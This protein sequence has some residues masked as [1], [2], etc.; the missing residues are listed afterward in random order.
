MAKIHMILQGKGGVG[1]SFIATM[2]AQH[3]LAK[4][5]N[6][7]CI[8]TDP[9]N[10]T[11]SGFS[12]LNVKQLKLMEG[13][14]INPRKFDGLIELIA[15]SKSDVI[16]DNGASTFVPL[17]HYLI[18]NN[19]PA[20]LLE[21]GHELVVH[22]VITGSQALLDTLNGFAQLVR[23]FPREAL[24]TVWLNPFWGPIEMNGK[25][26]EQMKAY[27]DNKARVSAIIRIPQYKA[28]TFGRDISDVLQKRLTFDEAIQEKSLTLMMRQRIK[29]VKQ[30]VFVQLENAA[31][32]LA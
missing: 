10:A 15:T 21:M 17:S 4:G 9:V 13:D 26:F 19:V 7:L 30:Q 2:L 24:F 18:S 25:D 31:A 20:L 14:E 6:P 28:D 23:Q 8:D 16:I 1:K 29:I 12:K 22:T 11:F 3:K 27:Q 32:V 5:Q